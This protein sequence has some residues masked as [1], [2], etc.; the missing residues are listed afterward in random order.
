MVPW[1]RGPGA[2]SRPR[3]PRE[4]A[5]G[6]Q[7]QT[8]RMRTTGIFWPSPLSFEWFCQ[9]R[10]QGVTDLPFWD[11][12]QQHAESVVYCS[13]CGLHSNPE[14][15]MYSYGWCR[16]THRS[17]TLDTILQH[18]KHCQWVQKKGYKI[19]DGYPELQIRGGGPGTSLWMRRTKWQTKEQDVCSPGKFNR[20][21]E[22]TYP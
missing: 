7:A 21:G 3:R 5:S 2:R 12:H 15:A 17:F 22:T 10:C 13:A 18:S 9:W 14:K 16:L 20:R 1:R 11:A 4:E 8:A 6:V 19:G